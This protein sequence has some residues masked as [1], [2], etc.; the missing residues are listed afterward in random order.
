MRGVVAVA[1]YV[2]V[3]CVAVASAW[4]DEPCR[5]PDGAKGFA[6]ASY[7]GQWYEIGK[8]QTAGGAFFERNCVCTQ[9]DVGLTGGGNAYAANKCRNKT[10]S[11]KLTIAN[12]TLTAAAGDGGH[13][14][15][16]FGFSKVAY[17]VIFLNETFSIEYDC[18]EE[19]GV[20][21]YCFHVLSRK[22]TMP[23][24]TLQAFIQLAED[25]DLNPQKL[26]FKRTNQTGCW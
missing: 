16:S 17:N 13:F 4:P 2:A 12:G 15:E 19:L 3:A 20:T 26:P 8:I 24:S 5:H 23:E 1:V 14:V 9:I 11:G 22:P 10:P 6:V 7:A 21:N 18:G 25:L